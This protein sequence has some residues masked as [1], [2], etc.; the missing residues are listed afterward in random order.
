[1]GRARS[2]VARALP[3]PGPRHSTAKGSRHVARSAGWPVGAGLGAPSPDGKRVGPHSPTGPATPDNRRAR[4][5]RSAVLALKRVA[6]IARSRAGRRTSKA[7]PARREAYRRFPVR[8]S[9]RPFADQRTRE[10]YLWCPAPANHTTA[11]PPGTPDPF[12]R[13]PRHIWTPSPDRPPG[14]PDPFAQAPAYGPL[15]PSPLHI[16]APSPERPACLDLLA[17]APGIPGLFARPAGISGPLRPSDRSCLDLF[18]LPPACADPF[19]RPPA[20]AAPALCAAADSH[21]AMSRILKD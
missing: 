15:R 10:P 3:S 16:W 5:S 21:P 18:A 19:A 12:A 20:C 7:S 17:R 14:I 9:L 4:P 6:A 11:R 2:G 13:P 1:M 8:R